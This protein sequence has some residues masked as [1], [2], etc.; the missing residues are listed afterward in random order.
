M[1]NWVVFDNPISLVM[2]FF[3]RQLIPIFLSVIPSYSQKSVINPELSLRN[4]VIRF[5]WLNYP[6]QQ[7]KKELFDEQQRATLTSARK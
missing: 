3:H 7:R 2:L 5:K 1:T 4:P 6:P